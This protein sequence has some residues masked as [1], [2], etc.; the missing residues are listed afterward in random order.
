MADSGNLTAAAPGGL[1]SLCDQHQQ[2]IRETLISWINPAQAESDSHESVIRQLQAQAAKHGE[3]LDGLLPPMRIFESLLRI[4][5]P[6]EEQVSGLFNEEIDLFAE[7]RDTL[8]SPESRETGY[9][10][11]KNVD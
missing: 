9:Q 1:T 6:R 8:H 5:Q 7:V 4:Q 3:L 11:H 10:A 2:R